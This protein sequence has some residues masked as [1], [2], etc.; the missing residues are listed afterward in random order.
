[1]TKT[2]PEAI[3]RKALIK[4]LRKHHCK[5]YRVEPAVR[6]KFGLGDLWVSCVRKG[7]A[8]WIEVKTPTGILNEDQREFEADCIVC[9]VK[10]LVVKYVEDIDE[11]IPASY[12]SIYKHIEDCYRRNPDQKEKAR[13]YE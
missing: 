11:I 9:G 10:Y 13:S 12:S 4:H 3:F 2:Q 8:G 7:W 1:M 5:V 6:G